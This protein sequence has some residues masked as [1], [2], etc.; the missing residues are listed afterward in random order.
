MKN[1][2]LWQGRQRNLRTKSRI[3]D[4]GEPKL[5]TTEK[6]LETIENEPDDE[7]RALMESIECFQR[8]SPTSACPN[9]AKGKFVNLTEAR[10]FF[11]PY[12]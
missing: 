4:E 6:P 3:N 11:K 8:N 1:C 5:K 7:F 10:D 9:A 12:S 2:L